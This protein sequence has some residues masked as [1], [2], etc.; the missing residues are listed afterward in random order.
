MKNKILLF[1]SYFN[2][3]L[4]ITF[5]IV[6]IALIGCQK[7]EEIETSYWSV[8]EI[9]YTATTTKWTSSSQTVY[10]VPEFKA[11]DRN[12]GSYV[13][14]LFNKKPTKSGS[15]EVFIGNVAQIPDDKLMFEF[16]LNNNWYHAQPGGIVD[17][18]VENG[19]T[20]I[21]FSNMRSL[22]GL[23]ESVRSNGKL[24]ED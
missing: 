24:I 6:V 12:T 22:N 11:I 17:V 9:E 23:L 19:K 7:D 13:M 5:L 20:R 10:Q 15:Y 21:N 18:I 16:Y 1:N 8:D 2:R 3:F 4:A 14:V